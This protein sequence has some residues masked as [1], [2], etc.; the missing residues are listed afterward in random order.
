MSLRGETKGQNQGAD[1]PP[2]QDSWYMGLDFGT[3]GARVMVIDDDGSIQANAKESYPEGASADWAR[4]WEDTLHHLLSDLPADVKAATRSISFDGTSATTMIVD[5]QSGESLSPPFLYNASCPDALPAVAAMAPK[6]HTVTTGTSTLCK[7][8]S[9]YWHEHQH[10]REGGKDSVDGIADRAALL[11]Q[12]DWL[13][14]LLHGVMGVSDYNNALKLG[15]DPARE[16]YPDWLAFQPFA[17]MLPRIVAP[18]S[19]IGAVT[20]ELADRHGFPEDCVV[21]AGTTDSIAAFLAAEPSQPGEAVT[22]L[23]STLAVKLLSTERV[24]DARFGIYSHRLNDTWLVGGASNTGGAVLRTLFTDEQ[25][26]ELTEKIDASQ[27][28]KLRYYP[29]VKPGERFPVADPHLEPCLRPRPDDDAEFL[30]GIL[31]ST[32]RIEGEAY[33]LLQELGASPLTRVYTAGGGA[34]NDKWTAIRARVLGV[35][36]EPS[37]QTE[38]AYGAALLARQ[39]ARQRAG[40]HKQMQQ[41][42]K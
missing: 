41:T 40:S 7:L 33:R 4:A 32:A 16:E 9:W 12:A 34:V 39:G 35:P 5:R 1:G 29:L 22:S 24:D 11:H 2:A 31:E 38:A 14:F 15:Y 25:L 42:A 13:A 23:G 3:S 30:H 17:G 10:N 36:V 19:V 37:P 18:G 8:V 6:H 28:S 20:K 21:C 26:A 27:E